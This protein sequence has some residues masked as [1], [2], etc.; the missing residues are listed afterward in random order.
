MPMYMHY[1]SALVQ[2]DFFLSVYVQKRHGQDLYGCICKD[3]PG[4][5]YQLLIYF[6]LLFYFENFQ[7]FFPEQKTFQ[8]LF[9]H[10]LNLMLFYVYVLKGEILGYF[11][12]SEQSTHCLNYWYVALHSSC[13]NCLT[14]NIVWK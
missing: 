5:D 12:T 9:N 8:T 13:G 1:Y 14:S 7:T 10:F 11:S 6:L 4:E 2:F 3:V